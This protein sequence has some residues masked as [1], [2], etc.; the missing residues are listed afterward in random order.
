VHERPPA[1]GRQLDRQPP[2]QPLAFDLV[3]VSRR[4]SAGPARIAV[5]M[6]DPRQLAT[7]LPDGSTFAIGSMAPAVA[8]VGTS[9][10]G[11][12]RIHRPGLRLFRHLRVNVEIAGWSADSGEVRISPASRHVRLWGRR[13]LGQYF[14]LV[15]AVAD[16]LWRALREPPPAVSDDAAP[17]APSTSL[18]TVG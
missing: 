13:R 8:L 15:H 3:I 7:T 18:E 11:Q 9:W 14:V 5:L 10:R 4:V 2:Y 17:A 16:H 12:A 1:F 6:A